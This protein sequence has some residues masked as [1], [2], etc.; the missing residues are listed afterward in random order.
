M[1]E[2]NLLSSIPLGGF[3]GVLYDLSL[4]G[5]LN[6]SLLFCDWS[7]AL[8]IPLYHSPVSP[9]VALS[10]YWLTVY[11]YKWSANFDLNSYEC[12]MLWVY[13]RL[14][15]HILYDLKKKIYE[16]Y[17]DDIL[18]WSSTLDEHFE[19]L[20]VVFKKL[21]EAGSQTETIKL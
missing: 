6:I 20:D 18:I 2:N 5:W 1:N 19:R 12:E 7:V 17:L 16:I 15:E 3:R 21:A 11:C 4:Q 8:I 14:M 9:P 10:L 13:C